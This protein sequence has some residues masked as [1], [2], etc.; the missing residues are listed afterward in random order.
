MEYKIKNCNLFSLAN[1]STWSFAHCISLDCAMGAGIAVPMKKK[2]KLGGL[3]DMV[4]AQDI[5]VPACLYH[6]KVFNLITKKH[7]SGKPTYASL[8]KSIQL[9]A[10]QVKDLKINKLAMPKIACGLDGCS[11]PLVEQ[12]IFDAFEEVE[13]DILVCVL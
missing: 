6:H 9:M 11:W 13:V 8:T 3:I 12:I 7:A 5:K 10:A 2:F 4:R 1:K